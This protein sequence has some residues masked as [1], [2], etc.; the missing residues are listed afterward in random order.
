MMCAPRLLVACVAAGL[1]AGC[2]GYALRGK[3][4]DGAASQISVVSPDDARLKSIGV[5]QATVQVTVDPDRL[6]RKVLPPQLVADDGSFSVPIRQTG[7]GVLEYSVMV[8]V[9][10]GGYDSAAV[11]MR[12]PGGGK[13]LLVTLVRGPDHYKPT[14]D[15][16][17]DSQ[18][19]LREFR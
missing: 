18:E 13:R 6:D 16:L 11:T 15:P 12:L 1:L 3:V 2:E 10:R 14:D 9:R 19:F 4:V 8:V 17:R 5:P 7:A